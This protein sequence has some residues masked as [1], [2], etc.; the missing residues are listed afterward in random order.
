MQ[1]FI[2]RESKNVRLHL[3]KRVRCLAWLRSNAVTAEDWFRIE[4]LDA[5]ARMHSVRFVS[6]NKPSKQ[7]GDKPDLI[8]NVN[9]IRRLFELKVLPK[10]G[11][12]NYGW[13]RFIAG[14]SNRRDFEYL[15]KGKRDGVIYIYWYDPKDWQRTKRHLENSYAVS[16]LH[17]DEIAIAKDEAVV[18]SYWA[19]KKQNK[20]APSPR[21]LAAPH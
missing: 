16:C 13:Q 11:S 7:H 1:T 14:N 10:G 8:V 9:G 12:Y 5:I 4:I 18:I 2:D 20:V 15:E 21:R 3:K 19:P 6:T 17:E